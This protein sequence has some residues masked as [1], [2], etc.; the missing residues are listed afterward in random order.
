MLAGS[1]T[2]GGLLVQDA[3]TTSINNT[4]IS[5]LST[6][7][8]ST[9]ARQFHDSLLT[10]ATQQSE[11]LYTLFGQPD[12]ILCRTIIEGLASYDKSSIASGLL[13]NTSATLA[14]PP[15]VPASAA[16]ASAATNVQQHDGQP[17]LQSQHVQPSLTHCAET[18]SNCLLLLKSASINNAQ[19]IDRIMSP[20]MKILQKLYRDHLSTCTTYSNANQSGDLT[21]T[22]AITNTWTD[23]LIQSL[24]LV[25]NRVGVMSVEMRK[26]FIQSILTTLIDK[27]TDLKL[28]RYIVQIVSEWIKYKQGPLLNQ[29]PS[30]K[31]RL[32]LLQR[33]A[34]T[35]EKRYADNNELQQLFLQT[36][37]YVYKDEVYNVNNEFKIKLENAFLSGLKC[38]NSKIRQEFFEIFNQ[39]LNNADLYERLCYIIVSQNW[40]AFGTHYW[41]KQCIQM[42]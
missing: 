21:N 23:L 27:S 29:I 32:A 3:L 42:T 7:P 5:L 12:G 14:S 25:K 8:M 24:E 1:N 37:A 22:Q 40:E 39:N 30:M 9:D 11:A 6:Q 19:Y 13:N 38:A 28:V 10:D 20:F 33:L 2:T 15:S 35:L 36:I 16:S 18:L 31:E 34:Q 17:V 4:S 26:M 41:I